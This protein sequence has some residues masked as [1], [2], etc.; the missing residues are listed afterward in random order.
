MPASFT[1]LHFHI[2]FSTKHREKLLADDRLPP[3]FKYIG[4]I[5]DNKRCKLV[6]SG[7]MPDHV[8]LL[9][10]HHKQ[11]SVADIVRDIKA[12]SSRWIHEQ[13]PDLRGFA[14]QE[15]YG[16]FAVSYSLLDDV[17]AYLASQAEHHR[18]R[19]FQDEFRA[20]LERHDI[21]YDE[22]YIWD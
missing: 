7:G 11:V 1:C 10:S 19:T 9:T 22:R 13:F 16:A 6:D 14:W 20:F 2:V 18:T 8:H 15:G 12:N 4:G 3:L 21:P 17:K 5:L